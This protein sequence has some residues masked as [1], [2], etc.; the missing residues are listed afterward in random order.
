MLYEVITV[1]R[2]RGHVVNI[3]STAGSWPYRGGNAYGGTKAFVTQFSR[4]LR[5]DLQ[6]V[7]TSYSIHYTKLYEAHIPL[8]D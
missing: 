5:T 2:N 1:A 8:P 4:N 3:S 6:G 7:I